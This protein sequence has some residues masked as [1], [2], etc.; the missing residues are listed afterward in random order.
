M[1]A[2]AEYKPANDPAK[3]SLRRVWIRPSLGGDNSLLQKGPNRPVEIVKQAEKLLATHQLSVQI[4]RP[5]PLFGGQ[6]TL[7]EATPCHTRTQKKIVAGCGFD[8]CLATIPSPCLV[9]AS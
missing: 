2:P 4:Q 1:N 9:V 8:P 6:P 3:S 7:Q 5:R